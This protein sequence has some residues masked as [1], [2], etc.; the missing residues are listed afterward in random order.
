MIFQHC[1]VRV[2]SHFPGQRI[3]DSK[4]GGIGHVND[5]AGAVSAFTGQ[6]VAQVI[7]GKRNTLFNKPIDGMAAIFDD[8]S[9][10]R[11]II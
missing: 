2:G 1:N 9:G 10:R 3:L 4:S 5:T 8:K 11:F 7:L 6:V